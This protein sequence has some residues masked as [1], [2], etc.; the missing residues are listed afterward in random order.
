MIRKRSVNAARPRGRPRSGLAHT[1]ILD[2]ALALIRERGFDAV[3]MEAIAERAG[4]GK[5]TVYRRW[6][7]R[8]LLV[9][10]AIRRITLAMPVPDTGAVRSDLE[11]VQRGT[12]GMYRDPATA[13]LLSGLVAAM[14]RSEPI[15]HAVRTGFVATRRSAVRQVLRRGVARGELRRS[16]DIELTIDLLSGSFLVRLLITGAPIDERL[17]RAIVDAVLRSAAP[18]R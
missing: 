8:E 4:V 15:A 9:V 13:A 17:S 6:P 12:L 1:A 14:A 10:E 18:G 5:T 16:L 7:S 2:A 3:T 11:V